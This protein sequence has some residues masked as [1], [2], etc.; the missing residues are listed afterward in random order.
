MTTTAPS[1]HP[2]PVTADRPA[3]EAITTLRTGNAWMHIATTHTIH[4]AEAPAM[5]S[6]SSIR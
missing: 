6:T 2:S 1:G 3:V 4:R 5:A